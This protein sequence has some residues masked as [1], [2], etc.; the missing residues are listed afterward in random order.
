MNAKIILTATWGP[1]KGQE[2]VFTDRLTCTVG[3]SEDCLVR[4]GGDAIN[5]TVSRRHCLLAIDP[6]VAR[7]R[8][9]GSL[10]GTFVNGR[11][12]G[13]REKDTPSREAVPPEPEGS[14]STTV[15]SWP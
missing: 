7:V 12:I 8:D 5:L 9:L 13:Q 15:T 3:R 14:S 1:L 4:I 6:P 10:N 11:K 2:F